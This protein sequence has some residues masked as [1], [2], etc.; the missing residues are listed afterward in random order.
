MRHWITAAAATA[1]AAALSPTPATAAAKTGGYVALGDSYAAGIGAGSYRGTSCVQSTAGSYPQ[2]WAKAN[3]K[4]TLRFRAC[5]GATT[6]SVRKSQLGYL[7]KST[8]WVTVTAGGNDAGFAATLQTCYLGADADC[9]AA[10]QRSTTTITSTL[11]KALDTLYSAI[12]T[13]AP[14]AK[15]YVVGYPYLVTTGAAADCSFSAGRRTML[16]AASDALAQVVKQRAAKQ[17]GFVFI[18]GRPIFSGHEVC[19][20][21]PWIHGVASNL[22]ESFH[23]TAAGHQAYA[24]ALRKRTT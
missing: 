12:R 13:R 11:P 15:V 10:T 5:S 21:S 17:K 2:L 3:P 18:D 4:T 6:A 20:G 16:N 7:T 22:A 23:P 24:K 14:K 9:A 19:T 8:R 1:L